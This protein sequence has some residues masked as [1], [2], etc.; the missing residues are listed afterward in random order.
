MEDDIYEGMLIPKG[1]LVFANIWYVYTTAA[2]CPSPHLLVVDRNILR[3]ETVFKDSHLFKP[4]RY[5]EQV[6]DEM[7]K[8][9][10]P[11]NYSFGFGRRVRPHY[12]FVRTSP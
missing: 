1:T 3:D 4:E 10:D 12:L 8:R 9:R 6:D 5:L 7:A 11:K 2:H